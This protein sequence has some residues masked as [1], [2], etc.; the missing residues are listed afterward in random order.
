MTVKQVKKFLEEVEKETLVGFSINTNGDNAKENGYIVEG[1]YWSNL[2]EDVIISL[3][4]E[5]PTIKEVIEEMYEVYYNF[6][7]EEHAAELYYSRGE[8]GKPTSL[9][10]LLEDA[11]RQAERLQEIYN[12]MQRLYNKN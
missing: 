12:I 11:D 3:V 4:I 9:R 7:P 1:E 8:Y 10:E 2:G 5:K 6:D